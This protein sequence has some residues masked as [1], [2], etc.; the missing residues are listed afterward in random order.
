MLNFSFF[1]WK[2]RFCL[3]SPVQT[4]SIDEGPPCQQIAD[5]SLT[6]NQQ[7]THNNYQLSGNC[8]LTLYFRI[9]FNCC[10]TLGCLSTNCRLTGLL[11]SCFLL[12]PG[13]SYYVQ[14]SFKVSLII[15][16]HYIFSN[17]IVLYLSYDNEVMVVICRK[18]LS[19]N[20]VNSTKLCRVDSTHP[21]RYLLIMLIILPFH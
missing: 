20:S 8:W 7:V 17:M 1:F 19:E 2:Q 12:L 9:R 5:K 3:Q 4:W 21:Q 14:F 6:G 10:L 16:Y 18:A 11:G 13:Q 15:V